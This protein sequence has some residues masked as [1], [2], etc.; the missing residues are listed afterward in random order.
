MATAVVRYTAAAVSD[1]GRKRP[2]NE[3]AYGFSIEAGV[4]LVCDGMG[5]AAAG[6]VAS[7]IAVD[8]ILRLLTHRSGEKE[9]SLPDA[10]QSAICEANEAIFTRAQR[11][12]RLSGMGTTLVALATREQRV[13]VLNVGDSRCYR[14][15]KGNLEQLSRDHSLVEEQVRLGR[16]TPREALHSPL[17]NVI[18]RALG[19]QSQVTPDVF[20]FDAEPG[21]LFLLCSDGLTRELSDSVIQDLLNK[22]QSLETQSARLVDAAKKAGGHDNITC[23]LVRAEG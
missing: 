1:R 10:A 21:D 11:N 2:S 9:T 20:E 15:R 18:T 19:T 7:T 3:D 13:W 8:E 22:D 16:M 6:E 12:H 5:G 23:L 17:R 14:L 4:Y